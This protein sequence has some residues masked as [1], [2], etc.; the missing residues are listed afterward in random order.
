M[1]DTLPDS[2]AN[3][4]TGVVSGVFRPAPRFG[5]LNWVPIF[6]ANCGAEGGLVPEAHT[7]FAF[8]LCNYCWESHGEIAGTMAV[9]D[10]VFWADVARKESV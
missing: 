7:T 3:R 2:R 5:R 6:C 1:V 4:A 8:W 9:P 10:E